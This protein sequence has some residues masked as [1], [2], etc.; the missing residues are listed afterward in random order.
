V[1]RLGAAFAA[2]TSPVV[3]VLDDVHLLHNSECRA[4]LS[5]LADHVPAGSRLVLAGRNAPPLRIARLRAEG[6]IAEVGP[7]D[8]ALTRGQAAELLRAAQVRLGEDEVA[9]LHR[10]TEGWPA[11]LYLAALYLREGGTP[12][13]A[14]AAFGGEDRFVSE[15]LESELLARLSPAQ[16]AFLTRTAVLERMCGPLCE[17]VLERPGAAT[18]LAD[19]A[20]SNLLLVPLDRRGQWYRYHHLF[21]DMLLAE[22]ERQ[23]PGLIPVL[24]RRAAAW[25][26]HSDLA[27]EALEYSIAAGDVDTAARLVEQ[28]WIPAYRQARVTTMQ[29]WVKWLDDRAGIEGRPVVAAQAALLANA[30]GRAA[31]A[32]RWADAVDRWQD[33]DPARADDPYTEGWAASLRAKMCRHGVE[34]MRADADDATRKFAAANFVAP[35]T[36]L[37]QGIARV[38]CGDLD[39]G[40]AFLQET[41][42][43]WEIAPDTLANALSQ[44]SLVAIA[45]NQWS[46]AEA[47][48]TEAAAV[49]RRAGTEDCYAT[50]AEPRAALPG[51]SGPDRDDPRLPRLGRPCRGEDADARGR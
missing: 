34:Q 43:I 19:L 29:R 15:Y 22:L 18:M 16:R 33:Q 45:R 40:D 44:R 5:V 49:L 41:I 10:R 48:A 26:L 25:C 50:P 32:E 37:L 1:P 6:R 46:Q 39:G 2:M 24:R 14:A 36:V 9:E 30:T 47:L 20:Q 8:L 7:A 4:A 27:E 13:Q 23:A 21:R 3:L 38:L 42:S 12:G 11:G 51:R 17:A 28:L 35:A 31:E